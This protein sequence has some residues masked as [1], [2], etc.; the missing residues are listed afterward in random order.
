MMPTED[1]N[2]SC[3]LQKAGVTD[4]KERIQTFFNALQ[5]YDAALFSALRAGELQDH[6]GW[7][8]SCVWQNTGKKS[9]AV[10][11]I[12]T[13]LILAGTRVMTFSRLL[14]GVASLHLHLL[15]RSRMRCALGL[16]FRV[17]EMVPP[18]I[19]SRSQDVID[20]VKAITDAGSEEE[21]SLA[22]QGGTM[23][24]LNIIF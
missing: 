23:S 7:A 18:G 8:F 10:G 19:L 21:A 24:N 14:M 20:K 13:T 16:P 6:T 4:A 3:M 2:W 1:S 22:G 5:A 9:F 11:L 15:P 12:D 17:L